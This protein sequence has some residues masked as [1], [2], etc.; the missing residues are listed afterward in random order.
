MTWTLAF[1]TLTPLAFSLLVIYLTNRNNQELK[2]ID[3]QS[4]TRK[5]LFQHKIPI[6]EQGFIALSMYR[7]SI[8]EIIVI[9]EELLDDNFAEEQFRIKVQYATD[10]YSKVNQNIEAT[11]IIDLYCELS[12]IPTEEVTHLTQKAFQEQSRLERLSNT[13]NQCFIVYEES[14]NSADY[15]LFK[16]AL[17]EEHAKLRDILPTYYKIRSVLDLMVK[18]IKKEV[19]STHD[20]L[21]KI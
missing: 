11:F 3:V 19:A 20:L 6:L 4:S 1:T 16:T 14:G 9:Y 2:K 18:E 12:T 13:R 21:G 8:N 15:N 5:Q 17:E 10:L 7:A